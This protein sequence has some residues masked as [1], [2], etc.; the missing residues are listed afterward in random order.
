VFVANIDTIYGGSINRSAYPGFSSESKRHWFFHVGDSALLFRMCS[1]FS[2]FSLRACANRL[3]TLTC[4]PKTDPATMRVQRP[5]MGK[6]RRT[7]DEEET[8]PRA[9][10][11]RK[12]R[13]AE[14]QMAAGASSPE[15]ARKLGISEATFHR[16]RNQYGGMKS[17]EM[18][19]L[20]ELEKENA[21]L[22]KIV[23]DQALGTSASSRR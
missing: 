17:D 16:W 4:S 13:V 20:K 14:A 1:L 18:K 15:L 23:A 8:H 12:L 21:R 5:G 11:V 10:I 2:A 6:R 19:R 7:L 22:K 3:A 9:E